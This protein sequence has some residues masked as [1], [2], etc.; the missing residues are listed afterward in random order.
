MNLEL[1]LNF[2]EG[3]FVH[4]NQHLLSVLDVELLHEIFV[5]GIQFLPLLVLLALS[6]N[7]VVFIVAVGAFDNLIKFFWYLNWLLGRWI[8]RPPRPPRM[9]RLLFDLRELF[10]IKLGCDES[11]ALLFFLLLEQLP[12]ALFLSLLGLDSLVVNHIFLFLLHQFLSEL[13]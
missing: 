9:L 2:F 12:F 3:D 7:Q 1:G 4:Q 5:L 11:T 13:L 10:F 8:L 6:S